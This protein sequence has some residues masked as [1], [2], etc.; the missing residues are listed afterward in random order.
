MTGKSPAIRGRFLL[1]G[2]CS[3]ARH[4][5]FSVFFKLDDV[6]WGTLQYFA[7][8]FE[9]IH[10]NGLIAAQICN[11]IRAETQLI[12]Q[13]VCGNA[14][15]LHCTPQGIIADHIYTTLSVSVYIICTK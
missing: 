11:C 5:P 13:G 10:G 4:L 7:E 1:L 14:L 6:I 3:A 9:G 15:F 12:N 2:F 8:F